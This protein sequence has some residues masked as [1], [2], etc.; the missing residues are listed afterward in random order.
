MKKKELQ[1]GVSLFGRSMNLIEEDPLE[2][3]FALNLGDFVS[4][5]LIS[6]DLVQRIG[7][8]VKDK[9]QS[10]KNQLKELIS[11]YSLDNTLCVLGFSSKEDYVI[12]NSI[13]KTIVQML[14][15][16]ACHI[17]LSKENAKGLDKTKNDLVLV[18]TSI[19]FKDDLYNHNI[20]YKLNDKSFISEAFMQKETIEAKNPKFS[21]RFKPFTA[22]NE[23]KVKVLTAIP[24]H[25]N[26]QTVGVI[27]IESYSDRF[28][29]DEYLRLIETTAML[30]ATSMVLQKMTDEASSLIEDSDA[31]ESDLKHMRAELTALIG[32]LGDQ[33]QLF[34]QRLAAAVDTKG[35]YKVSHSQN[36]ASLARLIC[37]NLG[38]NEKTTDLIYYA[39]LLQ[40]IGK[41]TLPETIFSHKG[42]LTPEEW[43]KLQ[44][45]PNV[46]INLLMNINFLSEVIPYIHYHK[47]RW[48]GQGEPEGLRGNSI[49]LGSRII[50]VADAF[51]AM[52]ADRP[53]RKAM[54]KHQALD[55]MKKEAERKWDPVIID[56]LSEI[57]SNF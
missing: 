36:T 15:L 10:L 51:S 14:D 2:E 57:I 26:A 7:K 22:L 44:N 25:N 23:D 52:T 34:V 11:I 54:M 42:T 53:Y 40:N 50:A 31:A 13:A 6:E 9:T 1:S 33:Q 3:I 55:V 27:V 35:Q 24:M 30:F 43:T 21:Q 45:H 12:Y 46:G 20:G 17:Y 19:E 56:A 37:K 5:H 38:L 48:D 41:I 18:G 32:D 39:G 49:P 29:Q 47:E 8:S 28:F 4:E 16:D